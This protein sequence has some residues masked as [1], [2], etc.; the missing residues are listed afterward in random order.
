MPY[1]TPI[2]RIEEQNAEHESS[3]AFHC[4]LKENTVQYSVFFSSKNRVPE[5]E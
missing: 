5:R 4:L 2:E 1:P 3:R